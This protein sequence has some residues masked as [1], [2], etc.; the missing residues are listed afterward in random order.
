MK[1]HGRWLS[2]ARTE[3]TMRFFDGN[4]HAQSGVC[5]QGNRCT[6]VQCV[7]SVLV[8]VRSLIGQKTHVGKA[9]AL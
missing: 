9:D 1:G 7:I 5:G 6:L 3:Y 8:M 2:G 4:Y